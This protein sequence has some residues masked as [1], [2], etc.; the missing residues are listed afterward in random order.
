MDFQPRNPV[1]D[2]FLDKFEINKNELIVIMFIF[3]VKLILMILLISTGFI[4]LSGDDFARML[5]GYKWSKNPFLFA[6]GW[7]PFQF[8]ILGAFMKIY[9]NIYQANLIVNG[10]FSFLSLFSFYLLCRL[11]FNRNLSLIS[12][13]IL[14]TLPWHVKLSVS[15]LAEPIYHFFF[16]TSLVFLFK[17]KKT[18]KMHYAFLCGLC[19]LISIMNRIEASI[20]YASVNLYLFIEIVRSKNF[21]RLVV[22]W[23]SI[24][25]LPLIFVIIWIML[26]KVST[27]YQVLQEDYARATTGSEGIFISI[28][29]YPGY[30]IILS[31][32][33]ACLGLY[34]IYK[35]VRLH[36][37]KSV[38]YL[39]IPTFYFIGLILIS[40]ITKADTL[41]AS[42]RVV[43]PIIAIMIPLSLFP[44][45]KIENFKLVS[46]LSGVI[47][48]IL[49]WNFSFT[50]NYNRNDFVSVKKIA[51]T[52]TK[53]W[54]ENK[55]QPNDVVIFEQNLNNI[56]LYDALA[57]KVLSNRPD[58]IIYYA[59]RELHH[60]LQT[61]TD[62]F[63]QENLAGIIINKDSTKEKLS[64]TSSS[65]TD[66]GGYRIIW[67][68]RKLSEVNN[69]FSQATNYQQVNSRILDS[70]ELKGFLLSYG[71]F[72]SGISTYWELENEGQIASYKIQYGVKYSNQKTEVSILGEHPLGYFKEFSNLNNSVNFSDWQY[73]PL[74]PGMKSGDYHLLIRLIWE[75]KMTQSN[76]EEPIYTEWT[77]LTDVTMIS[78]KRDV[79]SKLLKGE[80]HNIPLGLKT[81]FTLF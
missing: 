22:P 17:W 49:L 48:L 25:L 7:P 6:S 35:Y 64:E 28:L 11:F 66:I 33:I 47:F 14:A 2:F 79:I 44:F 77:Y 1:S 76:K 12:L 53:L 19:I 78:S 40:V 45:Y 54:K 27:N 74:S 23:L 70:V 9:P 67:N 51:I 24:I 21:K 71:K 42:V 32:L 15:G 8:W 63:S 68:K 69:N 41:S 39:T 52:L 29:K 36:G 5:A 55:L 43:V 75:T 59:Q 57:L 31:P 62:F 16:F 37:D 38:H 46:W 4:A 61:V 73:L 72:P 80:L 50:F 13:G 65:I 20:F 34:G 56:H 18:E 30:L 3:A 10:L 81:F 60:T 58:N 26:G